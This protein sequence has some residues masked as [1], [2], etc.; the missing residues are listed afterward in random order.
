MAFSL[1]MFTFLQETNLWLEPFA[2]C[3]KTLKKQSFCPMAFIH[4]FLYSMWPLIVTLCKV[5][6]TDLKKE[7]ESS[8]VFSS[9][10]G[11]VETSPRVKQRSTYYN[12]TGEGQTSGALE[13]F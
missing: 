3:A 1:N 9:H 7:L 8:V 6:L 10:Y 5:S 2:C 4:S 13:H 12:I 11:S